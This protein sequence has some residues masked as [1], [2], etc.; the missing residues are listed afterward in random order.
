MDNSDDDTLRWATRG[1]WDGLT[2]HLGQ[3]GDFRTGAGPRSCRPE[4]EVHAPPQWVTGWGVPIGSRATRF[5]PD[6][7]Y[8]VCTSLINPPGWRAT[9]ASSATSTRRSRSTMDASRSQSAMQSAI[10]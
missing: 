7:S 10:F 8:Q 9:A 2:E 3:Q 4:S 5:N 1:P 6:G